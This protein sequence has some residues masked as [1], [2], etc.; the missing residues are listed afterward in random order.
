[1]DYFFEQSY[2]QLIARERNLPMAEYEQCTFR[3][4][5][6]SAANLNRFKFIDC[7]FIDCN[8][9]M[10]SLAD[11]VMNK[12]VF[13][14]CKLLGLHWFQCDRFMFAVWF[15]ESALS[16]SSFYGFNIKK[17]VFEKCDLKDVD[18]S[19]ADMT[20]C[21]L[22]GCDLLH[23]MFDN[24]TLIKADLSTAFNFSLNPNLNKLKGA[25]FS[26]DNIS[27]LLDVFQIKIV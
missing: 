7:K 10:A 8:L 18:F 19:G 14:R 1:M 25:Q 24:T 17:T 13:E 26:R 27:G 11:T 20:E 5:D 22:K 21:K 23:A 2:Q 9:S 12:V 3:N 16:N 4:C 6:F 15:K